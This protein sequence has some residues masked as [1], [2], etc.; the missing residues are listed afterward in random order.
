MPLQRI[1]GPNQ[2]SINGVVFSILGGVTSTVAS[3]YPGKVVIGDTSKDDEQRV[4]KI[5]WNDWRGGQGIDRMDESTDIDRV[6]FSTSRL[7]YK[8]HHVLPALVTTT[9]D[10]GVSGDFT[11]PVLAELDEAIYAPHGTGIYK[12]DAT[13]DSWGSS[14]HTLPVICSDAI[15]AMVGGTVYMVFAHTTGYTYTTDGSSF[16]D[17]TE[18]V[19]YMTDWDDRLWGIDTSGQLRWANVIGTWKDDAQLQLPD[20]Y[21]TDLFVHRDAFGEPIIFCMTKVGLFAHDATNQRFVKTELAL[22]HHKDNGKSSLVWLDAMY[23]PAGM[24]IHK[25]VYG[26]N[27]AVHT[28]VGPDRDHGLPTAFR[29]NIVGLAGSHND[30]LAGIDSTLISNISR[31]LVDGSPMGSQITGVATP[32]IG[33]SS[34]QAWDGRGWETK[35]LS[36]TNEEGVTAMLA[37]SAHLGYRLWFAQNKRV[38]WMEISEEIINPNEDNNEAYAS[39]SETWTP[40]FDAGDDHTNKLAL[41]V[42]VEAQDMSSSETIIVSYA[43]NYSTA[44]WDDDTNW[45]AL[46]TITSSGNTEFLLPSSTTPEGVGFRAIRFRIQL[47]R[48][49]TTTNTPDMVSLL[50]RYR[51]KL[52][53]KLSFSFTIDM[54][55]PFEGNT[56]SE[57][58]AAFATA[59]VSNTLVEFT[60]RNDTG[61]TRNYWVDIISPQAL[62]FTGNDERGQTRVVLAEP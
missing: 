46:S 51:K 21:A 53:E 42:R 27:S 11:I 24:G 23:I 16:T 56:P 38:H 2:V 9:A 15:T 44:T 29:G 8:R 20:N 3:L 7:R 4:S 34:I 45:T 50:L 30:L 28:L 43:T 13:T 14:L 61:D 62:E 35:W 37:T 54:N 36:G 41:S 55:G 52:P 59:T 47:A 48:G 32:P 31:G 10:S 40:W 12:Y 18:D 6:W 49:T 1:T 60:Y 19:E 22:P 17:D 33:Y 39:S 58:R 57:L 5:I 26:S 25:Y